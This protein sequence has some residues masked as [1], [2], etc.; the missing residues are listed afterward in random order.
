MGT[1]QKG[2]REEQMHRSFASLRMTK[3]LGSE[4]LRARSLGPLVKARALRDDKVVGAE[5]GDAHPTSRKGGEKWGTRL[6]RVTKYR[7]YEN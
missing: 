3:W 4:S 6:F 1:R 7:L 2:A 5:M